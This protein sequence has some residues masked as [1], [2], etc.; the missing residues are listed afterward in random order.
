MDPEAHRRL[1]SCVPGLWGVAS[2]HRDTDWGTETSKGNILWADPDG[3]EHIS[4]VYFQ[5]SEM[6]PP[7]HSPAAHALLTSSPLLHITHHTEL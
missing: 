5:N 3:S 2:W 6:I 1:Y 4:S 7:L